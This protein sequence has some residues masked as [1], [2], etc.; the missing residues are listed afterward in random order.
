M[1]ISIL[2]YSGS[3][4]TTLAKKLGEAL[5]L[6]IFHLDRIHFMEGWKPKKYQSIL[7][8]VQEILA[9]DHWVMDGNYSN[10]LF[11]Q[12]LD[13]ADVIVYLDFNRFLC[14]RRAFKRYLLFRGQ[15]RE[16]LTPGCEEKFDL[17]FAWWI[18]YKQRSRR[19]RQAMKKKLAPYQDKLIYLRNPRQVEDYLQ[20]ITKGKKR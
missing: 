10:Y 1:K 2:G 11:Q 17:E 16:D 19:K 13:D 5:N 12:R 3:G 9:L 15:T 18:L 4:K 7:E 14:F 20:H 6:P 8:E